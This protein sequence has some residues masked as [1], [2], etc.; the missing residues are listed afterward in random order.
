MTSVSSDGMRRSE[1]ESQG[2]VQVSHRN[3]RMG[4]GWYPPS[5]DKKIFSKSLVLLS[6][7]ESIRNFATAVMYKSFIIISSQFHFCVQ[8][9]NLPSCDIYSF[10]TD[11]ICNMHDNKIADGSCT[12]I[13]LQLVKLDHLICYHRHTFR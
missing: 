3:V 12:Y 10:C 2:D 11:F 4:P 6:L 5:K 1:M 7:Q 13:K 8:N 9:R